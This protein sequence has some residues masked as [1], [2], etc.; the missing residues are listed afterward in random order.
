[1]SKYGEFGQ[2][3]P[4][5]SGGPIFVAKHWCGGDVNLGALGMKLIC[6]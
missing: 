1:M 4:Q 3:F 6:G 2:N 5:K